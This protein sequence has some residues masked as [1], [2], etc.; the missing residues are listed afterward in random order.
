MLKIFSLILWAFFLSVFC[1]CGSESS[2]VEITSEFSLSFKGWNVES[3]NDS[4]LEI[5][6]AP[7]GELLDSVALDT[8]EIPIGYS[9]YLAADAD[10]YFP[11]LEKELLPGTAVSVHGKTAFSIVLLDEKFRIVSVW[12]VL[13]ENVET[14]SSAKEF[15]SSEC[16][17]SSS[18]G[19][20]SSSAAPL[21]SSSAEFSSSAKEF[22]S[23]ASSS[24]S[25]SAGEI[26]SGTEESSSS[27]LGIFLSELKL[28]LGADTVENAV[29]VVGKEVHV[30]VPY[31]ENLSA[32]RLYPLDS[33]FDLRRFAEMEFLSDDTVRSAYRVF[34]GEILPPFSDTAFWGTTA[35]AMGKQGSAS[36]VGTTYKFS[37]TRN[38][39]VAENSLVVRSEIVECAWTGITG[40]KKLATG[41]YFSGNYLGTDARSIYVRDY[42]GGTPS[43]DTSDISLDMNFGKPY[44]SRPSA[45]SIRY[46]YAHEENENADY[47]QKGLVYVMLLGD[48]NEVVATGTLVVNANTS[49]ADTV[50]AI[51]YGS[52]AGLLKSGFAGTSGLVLGTGD[53]DISSVRIVFASSAFAHVVAGGSSVL[54]HPEKNY[55]GAPKASLT[56]ENFQMLYG[57]EK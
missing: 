49:S 3:W 21:S 40:G 8:F 36:V 24:S 38:V 37:S 6:I 51:S 44:S 11:E 1:S 33:A 12:R 41:I 10:P 27:S 20:S 19:K 9:L 4:S 28:L 2:P 5:H 16:L 30:S 43:T 35:D 54:S 14:S 47:P 55:R 39:T 42:S 7:D 50:V 56:I 31:G 48:Q 25:E 23:S 46:S 34:A 13:W 32:V 45:F 53:E 17:S 18:M 52:D 22:S 29:S 57:D 26:S 15:S